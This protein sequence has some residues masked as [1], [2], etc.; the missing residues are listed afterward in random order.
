MENFYVLIVIVKLKTRWNFPRFQRKCL[1]HRSCLPLKYFWR[2]SIHELWSFQ[3]FDS[4]FSTVDPGHQV[5]GQS[6]LS[7][8]FWPSNRWS[9]LVTYRHA[10]ISINIKPRGLYRL[11]KL[12]NRDADKTRTNVIKS[13]TVNASSIKKT[14]NNWADNNKEETMKSLNVI[15]YKVS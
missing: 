5:D 7:Q 6:W 15:E 14:P 13:P 3:F 1:Q 11:Q 12:R 10:H 4:P 2:C 8:L 9:I